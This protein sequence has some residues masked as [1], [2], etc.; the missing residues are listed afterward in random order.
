MT[1]QDLRI[2]YAGSFV[3]TR[4]NRDLHP[5]VECARTSR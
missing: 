3:R 5:W 4:T 1:G 2:E